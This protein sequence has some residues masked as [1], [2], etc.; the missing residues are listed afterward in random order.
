MQM[1]INKM[2]PQTNPMPAPLD[3][4]SISELAIQD[5][6]RRARLAGAASKHGMPS[7]TPEELAA[8]ALKEGRSDYGFN[9]LRGSPKEQKMEKDT[10]ATYDIHPNDANFLTLIASKKTAAERLKR[11]LPEV[12]NGTGKNVFNQSGKDYAK[13]WNDQYEAAKNPKNKELM[14]LIN[15][16]YADGQKHGLPLIKDREK[17]T[18]TQSKK[19]SYSKGG[20]VDNPLPGGNKLI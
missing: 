13:D 14:D 2:N 1:A 18:T 19:V 11:T 20:H 6:Y 15:R 8:F 3:K 4:Y 10:F 16:A 7:L 17:N 12:W 9:S 5:L